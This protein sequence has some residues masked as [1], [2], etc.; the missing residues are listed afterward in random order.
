MLGA[1]ACSDVAVPPP[2]PLLQMS[3]A[4]G[5][6]AGT[7]PINTFA[8]VAPAV[9]IT[10]ADGD[11]VPNVPILFTPTRGS[12]L[13]GQYALYTGPDGVAS[14]VS[15]YFGSRA[16]PQEVV[17]VLHGLAGDASVTFTGT[18]LPG[19]TSRVSFSVPTF[20]LQVA[21]TA[22]LSLFPADEFR[23]PTG[24]ALAAAYSSSDASIV[25]ASGTG[26][27]TGHRLG[28]ARVIATSGADADTAFIGV[29]IRPVGSLA[30]SFA[31]PQAPYAVAIGTDDGI[32]AVSGSGGLL[33]TH[34]P[35]S[36]ITSWNLP[37]EGP[38]LDLALTPDLS[39]AVVAQPTESAVRVVDLASRS[40][41]RVVSGL[42][43]PIRV[44][45]SPDGVHAFV[46]TTST[47]L[48]R[49]DLTTGAVTS[50]TLDGGS[51]GLEVD[52]A[53]GVLYASALTGTLYEI[54]L[55]TFTVLR[56]VPLGGTPQ[57][58]SLAPD[59]RIFIANEGLG[60]QVVEVAG[61]T[62]IE[63]LAGITSPFDVQVTR[64]G[65]EVYVSRPTASALSVVHAFTFEMLRT[66]GG[67]QYR[68][69]G[70][71]ADGRVI[72]VARAAAADGFG[73]TVVR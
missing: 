25:S 49:V 16:G 3:I 13:L 24:A 46:G 8:A 10:D 4:A 47:D 32:L 43:A 53:R 63:T 29:G 39:M 2:A 58:I 71:S 50:I 21:A 70:I 51:N 52:A 44:A 42:G 59:G 19:P 14:A 6:T 1:G 41:V 33:Y 27:V 73:I 20:N 64:D 69:I 61:F 65:M 7:L 40:V 60:L 72:A 9:L 12:G 34:D 17:A 22:Q 48:H 31:T 5:G 68:R 56:S 18:A 67:A 45:V 36:G 55:A 62:L 15:W 66:T 57:G 11:P 37:L 30:R 28:A 38:A 35:G 26:V 23:N 54:S